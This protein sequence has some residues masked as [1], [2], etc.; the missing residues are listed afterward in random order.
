MILDLD[1]LEVQSF[2]TTPD[3]P[4]QLSQKSTGVDWCECDTINPCYTESC[5]CPGGS[6]GGGCTGPSNCFCTE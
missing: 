2:T 5:G 3:L 1:E 4:E 6:N